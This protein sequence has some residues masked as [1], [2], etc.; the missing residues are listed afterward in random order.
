MMPFINQYDWKEIEFPSHKKDLKTF[1]LN[2]KS[3]ARNILYVPYNSQE[4]R[5]AYVLKHN[6]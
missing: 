4:I 2:D 1:E 5:P 6:F 3:L